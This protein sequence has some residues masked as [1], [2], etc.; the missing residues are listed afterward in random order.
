MVDCV[1]KILIF[2]DVSHLKE[3]AVRSHSLKKTLL[4]LLPAIIVHV[5][6]QSHLTGTID[7]FIKELNY[8]HYLKDPR[9]RAA[10]GAR[11]K[12]LWAP[13]TQQAYTYVKPCWHNSEWCEGAKS[14]CHMQKRTFFFAQNSLKHQVLLL[15][16]MLLHN[17]IFL[18]I[19]SLVNITL[20]IFF[21]PYENSSIKYPRQKVPK[22]I[23]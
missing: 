21:T 12:Q 8:R 23:T 6:R 5:E 19:I 17:M 16:V 15:L 13:I 2:K 7:P 1:S 20:Y 11:V 4:R 18:T 14:Q 22:V 10:S 3:C 9:R